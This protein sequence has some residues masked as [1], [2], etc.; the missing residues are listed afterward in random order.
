MWGLDVLLVGHYQ[1]VALNNWPQNFACGAFALEGGDVYS[2]F[3]KLLAT[4]KCPAVRV[5]LLWHGTHLY[6]DN[7]IPNITHLSQRYEQLALKYPDRKIYLSPFCEA[8]NIANPDKYLDIVAKN[9]PHCTPVW[10][11]MNGVWSHKYMNE[12]HG[13]GT[14]LPGNYL[15]SGDGGIKVG[16]SQHDDID[17][18]IT[19]EKEKHTHCDTFYFWISRF[20]GHFSMTEPGKPIN[21]RIG[22][23]T[24]AD[25]KAVA[26]LATDKGI[27]NIPKGMVVKSNSEVHSAMDN[28]G[29]K[30]CL[31]VP[32]KSKNG[33][34][35]LKTRT[36]NTI[37]ALRYFDTYSKGGFRYYSSQM[38][39]QVAQH[40]KQ[41][42]G[43][44]LTDVLS[45]GK[46]IAIINSG[47]YENN[48]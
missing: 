39:C 38:G 16:A 5:Q 31:I 13:G 35:V 44:P 25:F 28:K 17:L 3:D 1:S 32:H 6:S 47:F 46:V 43:S 48:L 10:T 27:T 20:N 21:E 33:L 2:F 40:A 8:K 9:A 14:A 34:L 45:D 18:D 29:D 22:W 30:L 12:V 7:D 24:A 37:D 11:P 36:G 15:R 41:L 19:H 23:P 4:G 42:S 26:F